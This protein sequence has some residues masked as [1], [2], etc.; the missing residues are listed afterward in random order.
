MKLSLG[1]KIGAGFAIVLILMIFSSVLAHIKVTEMRTM[2]SAIL[3][4]RIPSITTTSELLQNLEL[5]QTRTRDIILVGQDR[6]RADAARQSWQKQWELVNEESAGLKD[7]S[8]HFVVQENR[9]RVEQ[10]K[11]GLPALREAQTQIFELAAMGSP[12]ALKQAVEV[13]YTSSKPKTDALKKELNDSTSSMKDLLKQ[14]E[15][16]LQSA[17]RSMTLSLAVSA[18]LAVVTGIFIAVMMG[19]R[20]S[21]ATTAALRQAES[22]AAGDLTHEEVEIKSQDELGDLAK[23]INEMH[24]N[25][26]RIIQSIAENA[27]NVANA[28]D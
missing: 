2:E 20:I 23:A 15:G 17:G 10:V 27:Q 5:T 9:E 4:V 14:N 7:L 6:A 18:A 25:L 8:T 12:A 1:Q 13:L 28:S 3:E 22:I 11:E 24:A 21:S 19:R 26:R 16:D